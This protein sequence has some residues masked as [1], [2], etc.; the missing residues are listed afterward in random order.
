[1][2]STARWAR[3]TE[4]VAGDLA[5]LGEDDLAA[6]CTGDGCYVQF[7]QRAD[8]LALEAAGDTY[9]PTHRRLSDTARQWMTAG[10]KMPSTEKWESLNWQAG[11]RWPATQTQYRAAAQ[12]LTTTLRQAFGAS[13]VDEL[14]CTTGT[15]LHG[16]PF[17]LV[18]FDPAL[19]PVAE[20][21]DAIRAADQRLVQAGVELVLHREFPTA[22]TVA[23]TG[24]VGSRGEIGYRDWVAFSPDPKP[25][26][27][28]I[29]AGL[30][31]QASGS[32]L[33]EDPERPTGPFIRAERGTVAYL[34]HLLTRDAAVGSALT[35]EPCLGHLARLV[36]DGSDDQDLRYLSVT[37]DTAGA[38]TVT[39]F[40][41]SA[42]HR[43]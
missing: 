10:W 43:R 39:D 14:T 30:D 2:D 8:Y 13:E 4:D 6:I 3:F 7:V 33:V 17:T 32:R 37:T 22:R 19:R 15:A 11:V 40:I 36:V 24:I 12:L 31:G 21:S 41:L 5:R 1:M 25:V 42:G 9:L 27:V 38:V 20:V 26:L 28:V 35:A 18:A 34:R 29:C 16:E 23:V